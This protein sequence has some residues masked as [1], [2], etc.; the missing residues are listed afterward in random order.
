MLLIITAAL[1]FLL[2]Q[3]NLELLKNNFIVNCGTERAISRQKHAGQMRYGLGPLNLQANKKEKLFCYKIIG[4]ENVSSQK[5]CIAIVVDDGGEKLLLAEKAAELEIPLTFS[6]IPYRK[7]SIETAKIAASHNKPYMLHLPMQALSD[8]D[9]GPFF[10]GAK[11][12]KSKIREITANALA[13]LPGA[14]GLNN[15]RGSMAT[16]SKD[17]IQPV[18]VELQERG[19]IFVDSRTSSKTVAYDTAKSMNIPALQNVLFLDNIPEREAIK[20]NISTKR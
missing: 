11:T 16:E 18:L 9:D 5:A 4:S 17:I 20:K 12:D 6:I 13:S 15:H 7:N 8:G 1:F 14:I 19:L 2:C 3:H 10:I